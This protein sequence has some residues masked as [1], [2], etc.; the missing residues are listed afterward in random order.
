MSFSIDIQPM[1]DFKCI[2]IT[3]QR[4]NA[5]I[6]IISKG[7]LLNSWVS[8]NPH[9]ISQP[10]IDIIDG[11]D[12]SQGWN[13]FESNG[14]KSGK[15][16]PFSCRL[17]KGEYEHDEKQYHIEKFYLGDHALHGV[18]YNAVFEIEATH[19]QNDS[20]F[21]I[22]KYDYHKED[23]GFPFEYQVQVKWIFSEDN[24]VTVHTIIHNKDQVSFPMMD[25]WHP[26]FSLG[27]RIDDCTIQFY[28]KGMLAYDAALIP[29]GAYLKN[30]QFEKGLALEGVELDNGYLLDN[31][32]P[33]CTLENSQFKLVIS[34]SQQ[35]PFLQL[36]TPPERK[37][38]AI[39]NL[40][41]APDCFNNKMGL[42][43]MQPH[44]TWKLETQ[45]QLFSK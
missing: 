11:N 17:Y 38:I 15:M 37:S 2:R 22:L 32:N 9:E 45:F 43:I 24:K 10:S 20:A 33:N 28:N 7:G 8:P 16:N 26:Y 5:H 4:I 40:S 14:F 41:G 3:N 12:F 44:S 23:P 13:H 29:T 34:P 19:I 6:D 39:E 25:G 21:V 18:L 36:Y 35:Y 31:E 27:N 42:H 30:N 1:F